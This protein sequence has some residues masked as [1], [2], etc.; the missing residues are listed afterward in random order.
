MTTP[1][2]EAAGIVQGERLAAYGPPEK[3]FATIAGIWS[4]I[5]GVD[6]SVKQVG[7]MMM[8]LKLARLSANHDHRDS[9]VDLHGYARIYGEL[10]G[11]GGKPTETPDTIKKFACFECTAVYVTVYRC[12]DKKYRCA[13]CRDS[14][15][16]HFTRQDDGAM[17]T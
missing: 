12:R 13:T 11:E 5:L 15:N 6:V 4:A 7:L 9:L 1:A 8:G 14:A 16:R 3:A 17:S 2:D 10:C